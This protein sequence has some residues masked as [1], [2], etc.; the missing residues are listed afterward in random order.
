MVK[1]EGEVFYPDELPEF[2]KVYMSALWS[3]RMRIPPAFIEN[4][5]GKIPRKVM[6]G[7]P[8]NLSWQVRINKINDDL[9]FEGG[10]PEFVQENSLAHGEFL[11]FCY[12]GNSKFYV[13]IFSTNGCRKR[14]A[15]RSMIKKEPIKLLQG[16]ETS[17][18]G[19]SY[20][21]EAPQGN[22]HSN[23]LVLRKSRG[24]YPSFEMVMT[25]TYI[26]QGLLVSSSVVN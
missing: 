4:F 20:C 1:S 23:A 16:N 7:T 3:E 24:K 18:P 15:T 8:S 12:A 11:T 5:G 2:F 9:F 22:R 21:M 25:K 17:R 19:K 6:L 14:L 10:W 13:K 26:H